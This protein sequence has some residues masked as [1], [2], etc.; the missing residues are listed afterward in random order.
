MI[1][2]HVFEAKLIRQMVFEPVLDLQDDH[3]LMQFL[4]A[5]TDT[6]GGVVT[7]NLV[8]DVT[9]HG[10]GNIG[11]AEALDQI[12]VQVAGR[13]RATRAVQ[14]VCIGQVFVLIEVNLWIALGERAEKAPI[15]RGFLAVEQSGLG[16]PEDPGGFCAQDGATGMLFAQP[17]QDLRVALA[18]GVKIVP[19]GREDDDVGVFQATVDGQHHIA[20]AAD[21]LAIRADQAC[22][23]GR[24]QALAQ[25]FAMTQAGEMK[26]VLG[27]HQG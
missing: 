22:F 13:R 16:E 25:L 21:G 7:L 17:R 10:L 18:Q 23:E 12:N 3:V 9:G 20:E 14:V 24:A 1:A 5:K 2:G 8:Q 15:G 4:P 6:S 26:K 19:K 11:A 27:L